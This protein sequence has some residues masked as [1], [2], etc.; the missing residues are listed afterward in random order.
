M[1][2]ALILAA[3]FSTQGLTAQE[4]FVSS[5]FSDFYDWYHQ[6]S[7]VAQLYEDQ[8]ELFT[9]TSDTYVYTGPCLTSEVAAQ[10][11]IGYGVKNIAYNDDYYLP[12]DEINGYGDIWYHVRGKDLTGQSFTGYIWGGQIAKGWRSADLN[13]DGKPEF[14]MLGISS[15]TRKAPGD[16]NAE[17]RIVQDGRL[18]HQKTVPGLCVFEDCASSPLLRVVETPQGFQIIEAS[19][20][21]VGCW[22]GI[23]KSF[24]YWDGA[25][26]QRV[27]QAEYTTHKELANAAFVFTGKAG[28]QLC[29]YSHEGDN[30]TPVW[31]CKEMAAEDSRAS[32][33]PAATASIRVG[34]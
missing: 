31:K 30:Y 18:L 8:T 16:I 19:T 13:G 24:F 25:N 29:R 6:Q 10:L 22:A 28:A 34:R 11:P 5:D 17:L 7:Q 1:R 23:E 2:K 12:E 3:L 15:Q 33:A 26:L 14:I 20:M 21:T 9:F 32:V 4:R 27:Y